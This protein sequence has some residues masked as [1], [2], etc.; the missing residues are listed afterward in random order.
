M[1]TISGTISS[2]MVALTSCDTLASTVGTGAAV[3]MALIVT[4]VGGMMVCLVGF[5]ETLVSTGWTDLVG[6]VSLLERGCFG[7][8]VVGGADNLV[9]SEAVF[10][11]AGDTVCA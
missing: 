8:T 11:A 9:G 4:G 1:A 2:S 3:I 10:E 6:G 7:G 5:S